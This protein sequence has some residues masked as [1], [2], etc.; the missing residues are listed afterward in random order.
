MKNHFRRIDIEILKEQQ[1]IKK[2]ENAKYKYLFKDKPKSEEEKQDILQIYKDI[3]HS[4]IRNP[5]PQSLPT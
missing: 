2:L 5:F 1:E 3:V 4:C